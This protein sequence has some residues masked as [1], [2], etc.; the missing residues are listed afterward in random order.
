MT[1]SLQ[2]NIFLFYDTDTIEDRAFKLE[3]IFKKNFTVSLK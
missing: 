3:K 2:L 1:F